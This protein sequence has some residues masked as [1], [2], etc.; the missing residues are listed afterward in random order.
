MILKKPTYDVK[1][2][3]LL[4]ET[5]AV[6]AAFLFPSARVAVLVLQS[7]N[8]LCKWGQKA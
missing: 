2:S 4:L 3:Q 5:A 8:L 6:V 7:L 1:S